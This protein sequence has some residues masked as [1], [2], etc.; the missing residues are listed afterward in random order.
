MGQI[1]V[2][3]GRSL[4]EQIQA[5]EKKAKVEAQIKTLERRLA[6]DKQPRKKREYFEMIRK[7]KES[8][9]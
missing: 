6:T 7:L 8:I 2:E 9:S 3:E 4:T 1:D 5:D